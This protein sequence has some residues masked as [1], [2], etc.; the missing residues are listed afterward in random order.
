MESRQVGPRDVGASGGLAQEEGTLM[1]S[2]EPNSSPK[3]SRRT[4]SRTPGIYYREDRKGRR[5]YEF[6][7]RDVTGRQRWTGG[8]LT[9]KE[10]E[11]ARGEVLR[12][13]RRGERVQPIRSTFVDFANQWLESQTQLRA[14]TRARYEWA[15]RVHLAPRFGKLKVGEITEDHVAF[16]VSDMQRDGLKPATVRAVLAPLSLILGRAVRRG[17]ISTNA[18]AGLERSERPK[19]QRREMRILSRDEIGLLLDSTAPEHRPLIAT[20]TFG[21]LRISEALGLRWADVDLDRGQLHVRGQLDH[22][23]RDRADTKTTSGT[24][25]VVLM[26]ALGR[27][28]AEHRLASRYSSDSDP[29]FVTAVGSP[30]NRDNVRTRV[31]GPAVK[32]A[33]LDQKDRPKLRTHDLRHCFASLLIAGGAS[34]VFV[35]SQLGHASP[36]ITLD[37]YSHLFDERDHASKMAA[38]LEDGFGNILETAS[39]GEV[40][41]GAVADVVVVPSLRPIA[42]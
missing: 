9:I 21:G 26:P 36:S 34:V 20:L 7:Y 10:A 16:V 33:G 2:T 23:S 14:S 27:M 4:R 17:A 5:V 25:S 41:S 6:V 37:I 40:R 18:V 13:I 3:L 38:I 39:R 30:M 29:V 8:F 15:I 12:R 31:L 32:R 35:S 22:K 24:R 19:G 28:L 1:S 42:V 11:D